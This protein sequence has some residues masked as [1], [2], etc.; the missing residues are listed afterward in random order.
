MSLITAA[1]NI[2]GP[3]EN[4]PSRIL[5][6]LFCEI[7]NI[8]A[9]VEVIAFFYGNGIPC[10]MASQLYHACN[11]ETDVS[12]TEHMYKTFLLGIVYI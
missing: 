12:V 8:D 7:P 11:T 1:E 4:W 2:I 9:M 5:E 3:I 6:Y 10:S